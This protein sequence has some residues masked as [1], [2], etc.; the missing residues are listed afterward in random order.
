MSHNLH[1][2]FGQTSPFDGICKHGVDS[3]LRPDSD[4]NSS[5]TDS[6]A[7]VLQN[8]L[9]AN[10]PIDHEDET[11]KLRVLVASREQAGTNFETIDESMDL[12][13]PLKCL[14]QQP[15]KLCSE[16]AILHEVQTCIARRNNV[17][18]NLHCSNRYSIQLHTHRLLDKAPIPSG[19][20]SPFFSP[21]SSLVDFTNK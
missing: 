18:P 13:I 3:S 5:T 11:L 9:L 19:L 15:A 4:E 12:H 17:V 1:F 7:H 2:E 8:N 21:V 10:C 6:H 20:I 16:E 14:L